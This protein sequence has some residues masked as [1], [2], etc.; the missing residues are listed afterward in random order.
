MAMQV[1]NNA[2]KSKRIA[3]NTFVLYFRMIFMML[4]MLYTSRVILDTLG[5]EDYGIYNVVGGFVSMFALI[6]SALSSACSRF[7]NFEMGKGNS[8]RLNIVFSTAVTIQAILALIVFTLAEIIGVWYVNNVMVLPHDRLIAAN[9]CFQFSV[10]TFCMNLITVPFNASI[11][12]HEKMTAFAYISIYQGIATLLVTVLVAYNPFDKL[13]YYALLLLI[14]QLSVQLAYQLYCR[15]NFYECRFKRVF[16]KPLMKQMLSYSTWHLIGNGAT[17]LKNEGVNVVLNL[18]FG[19]VVN[20]ARGLAMQVNSAMYQ[21]AS[22]FMTAMNPQIT[23]SYAKGDLDYMF[24]L[25]KKG[26]RFSF[27]LLLLLSLPVLINTHFLLGIWLKEIPDNTVV[28]VQLAIIATLTAS[29]SAPLV[30]AQNATGKVRDYQ[31]VVGGVLLLNLPLSYIGLKFGLPAESVFVIAIFIEILCLIARVVMVPKTIR[32]FKPLVFV[33]NVIGNCILV[34][35]L[36]S[37][38]PLIFLRKYTSENII[39][40][41]LSSLLSVL[42]VSLTVYFVGC[43]QDERQMIKNRIRIIKNNFFKH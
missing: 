27:Y 14:V 23:Q 38:L 34:C 29:I 10:I 36:A 25:I 22:N 18:F 16:D 9:W 33:K 6:S 15:K 12:A 13:I 8:D 30:T 19:P 41:I 24:N 32:E 42:S 40:F 1:E 3:K 20:S 17:V 21:F 7:I 28:F 39:S 2:T 4:V 43:N 26:A 31:L 37:P 11:I 5:V 35:V